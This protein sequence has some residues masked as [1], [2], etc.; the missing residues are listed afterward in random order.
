MFVSIFTTGAHCR[1]IAIGTYQAFGEGEC[2]TGYDD[3]TSWCRYIMLML[4]VTF[5]LC[6]NDAMDTCISDDVSA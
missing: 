1:M 3:Q 2:D 6:L 5:A 4:L